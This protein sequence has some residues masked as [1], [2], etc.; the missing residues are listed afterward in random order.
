MG[1]TIVLVGMMGSGKTA[2]GRQLA[3]RLNLPFLDTD[4]EIEK[5]TGMRI[6]HIF[7]EQGEAA[8]RGYERTKIAKLLAGEPCVLSTGGGAVMD[9][10]TRELIA[11]KSTVIWLKARLETLLSRVSKD[12]NRPLLKTDNPAAKLQQLLDARTPFYSQAPIHIETDVKGF[13]ETVEAMLKAVQNHH[14]PLKE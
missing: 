10:G 9:A 2:L 7:E 5:A 14:I 6:S 1:Q 11:T 13:E 4:A 12:K 8:F 3:Q